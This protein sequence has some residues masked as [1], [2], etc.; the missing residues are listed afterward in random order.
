MTKDY[1]ESPEYVKDMLH[2]VNTSEKEYLKFLY[3]AEP[4]TA[5]YTH[6]HNIIRKKLG[7]WR[8]KGIFQFRDILSPIIFNPNFKGIDFGGSQRPISYDVDIVDVEHT[9]D[10]GRPVRYHSMDDLDFEPDFIFLS[11]TLEHLD[12]L[13]FYLKKFHEKLKPNG[14]FITLV[15]SYSCKRWHANTGNWM[16]NEATKGTPGALAALHKH[17]LVLSKT[18]WEFM[19]LNSPVE[20][21][22]KL[23]EYFSLEII[24]YTGDNSIFILGKKL[25]K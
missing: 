9:D 16:G 23:K 22:T 2:M 20:I 21:D 7:T 4:R 15:P 10:L 3:D 25:I 24:E 12:D 6:R 5:N 18:N 13:D 17:T 8:W 1:I 11:H 14:Y 19:G